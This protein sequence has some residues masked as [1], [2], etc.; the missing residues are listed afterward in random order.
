MACRTSTFDPLAEPLKLE[1]GWPSLPP[2]TIAD[3]TLNAEP[4]IVVSTKPTGLPVI[5]C[6]KGWRFLQSWKLTVIRVASGH[7]RA[8]GTGR[9]A[10]Y[11]ADRFLLNVPTSHVMFQRNGNLLDL[12]LSNLAAVP[13]GLLKQAEIERS[14]PAN[15]GADVTLRDGRRRSCR[16]PNSPT[17]VDRIAAIM[18]PRS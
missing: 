17:A 12:R 14:R 4:V 8:C 15:Y 1:E 7:V 2:G 16:T 5:F 10:G 6:P 18:S 9:A 11:R 3:A 13:Q